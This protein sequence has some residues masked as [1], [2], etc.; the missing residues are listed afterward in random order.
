VEAIV[1]QRFGPSACRLFRLL[2]SKN[3]LEQKQAAELAMI[4][5]AD[6]RQLLYRMMLDEFVQL[7]EVPKTAD[8][9]PQRTFYLWRIHISTVLPR[10]LN[11]MCHGA[12]NLRLRLEHEM[13]QE[14]EVL[15]LLEQIEQAHAAHSTGGAAGGEAR[16]APEKAVA[17]TSGQ[18]KQLERIRRVAAVLETSLL[19]LDDTITLFSA[20]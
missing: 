14:Q 19:R 4:S 17:L 16:A 15:S 6:T 20:F 10:V 1:S 9:A 11:H 3:C 5:L 13:Q 2:L 18:R 12:C 7:Q 8:H